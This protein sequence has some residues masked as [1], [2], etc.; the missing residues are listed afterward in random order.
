[1][2]DTPIQITIQV[3]AAGATKALGA[4]SDA[5]R[6]G[7]L[8][9]GLGAEVAERSRER[10]VGRGNTAPDGSAWPCLAAATLARKKKKGLGHQGALMEKGDLWQTIQMGNATQDSVEVGSPMA[11]AL[12]HQMGG[13]A[14]KG[15][16]A[17]IPARPFLGISKDDEDALRRWLEKWVEAILR[18]E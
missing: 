15:H 17:T 10:I 2:S 3:D 7:S 16:K 11:Y 1:M 12:I 13:K 4:L 9:A 8:V 5:V 18:G 6:D 14:G